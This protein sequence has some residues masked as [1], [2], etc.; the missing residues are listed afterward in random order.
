MREAL[1]R[2]L[3][4][5]PTL[6]AITVLSFWLLSRALEGT[7]PRSD[8]DFADELPLFFNT[9]PR[10]VRE[11]VWRAAE[12]VAEGG[13]GS[14][15]AQAVLVR[16][17]GA[18]LPLL[19]PQLDA[20]PPE[21]RGRVGLAL[22]PIAE[23]M[24][25]VRGNGISSPSEAVDFW[26]R[27]ADERLIDFKA[28][29]AKRAVTRYARRVTEMRTYELRELDTFALDEILRQQAEL[30][31]EAQDT[32]TETE[33]LARVERLTLAAS[34]LLGKD[35]LLPARADLNRA[36]EV[37][38]RW[39]VYWSKERYH[40]IA[41]QGVERLL[42][43]LLQ[44]QFASWLSQI[45]ATRFGVQPDGQPALRALGQR[46]P[47]TLFLFLV[48]LVGGTFLGIVVGQMSTALGSARRRWTRPLALATSVLVPA[49]LFGLEHLQSEAGRLFVGALLMLLIGGLLVVRH[50]TTNQEAQRHQDWVQAYR[51]LGASPL[52][53]AWRTLRVSSN[54]A[55]SA[56]ASQTSTLLTSVFVVE[57]ALHINGI[58]PT[59]IEALKTRDPSWI[60][61]ITLATTGL[62]GMLQLL[63]DVLLS[64]LDPRRSHNTTSEVLDA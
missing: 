54:L 21:G 61:L 6:G 46:A 45:V 37:N 9:R 63:S 3:W 14:A 12:A 5:V 31:D 36:R 11:E 55:I 2:L 23:R 27:F 39:Q 25:V 10:G 56:L 58:G 35:W 34:V 7:A 28:A 16:I 1:R 24:G 32:T 17:G 50:Q 38:Q 26:A 40:F 4:L 30:L 15:Q 43:P 62:V 64:R 48:G 42:A 47:A 20:L 60:I 51:A 53:A 13:P 22:M 18:G 49:A 57:F 19:L 44:T 41:L 8:R 59:T 33:T 29:A 52:L